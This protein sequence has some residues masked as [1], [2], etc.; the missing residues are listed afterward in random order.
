M[1]GLKIKWFNKTNTNMNTESL[2]FEQDVNATSCVWLKKFRKVTSEIS[3]QVKDGKS[4]E[5]KFEYII[6]VSTVK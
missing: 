5:Y 2:M 1:L 4:N 3:V 6:V